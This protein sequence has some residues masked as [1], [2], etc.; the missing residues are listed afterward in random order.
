MKKCPKCLGDGRILTGHDVRK[1][2]G[3]IPLA[4]L[5]DSMTPK[6]S[7]SYL[8]DIENDRREMNA[9]LMFAIM[10]AIKKAMR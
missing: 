1:L 7:A 9:R 4:L 6:R 2:R 10:K 3:Q 8:S 5:G